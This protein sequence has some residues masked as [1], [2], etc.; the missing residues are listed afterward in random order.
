MKN[1]KE[2][3]Y[4]EKQEI[5]VNYQLQPTVTLAMTFHKPAGEANTHVQFG[6]DLHTICN[7]TWGQ[8]SGSTNVNMINTNKQVNNQEASIK[9]KTQ[10]TILWNEINGENEPKQ[11]TL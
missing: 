3:L 2:N 10:R 1:L 8:V 11:V 7:N 5:D 6:Y 4:Q 9:T